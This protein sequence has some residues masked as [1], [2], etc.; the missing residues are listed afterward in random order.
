MPVIEQRGQFLICCVRQRDFPKVD[1][2][3]RPWPRHS[4]ESHRRLSSFNVVRRIL[5]NDLASD[6]V[7]V[8]K[9]VKTMLLAPRVHRDFGKS[10]GAFVDRRLPERH[11][12]L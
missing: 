9:V 10:L 5:R 8:E 3:L 7:D 6:G 1:T 11:H 2:H 4:P 12:G